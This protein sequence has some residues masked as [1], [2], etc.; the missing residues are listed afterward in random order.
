MAIDWCTDM[1]DMWA[2]T[3]F[4]T[5]SHAINQSLPWACMG[6]LGYKVIFTIELI[7]FASLG[8]SRSLDRF[9]PVSVLPDLAEPG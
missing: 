8:F 1:A 9:V 5:I 7:V 4:I 2:L 6:V 3:S